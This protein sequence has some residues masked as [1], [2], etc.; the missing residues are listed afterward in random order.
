MHSKLSLLSCMQVC[1]VSLL[2]HKGTAGS[3]LQPF[4]GLGKGEL[5]FPPDLLYCFAL[6]QFCETPACFHWHPFK[7]SFTPMPCG[8]DFHLFSCRFRHRYTCVWYIPREALWCLLLICYAMTRL[9]DLTMIA[10]FQ[11]SF[12]AI[13]FCASPPAPIWDSCSLYGI[14]SDMPCVFDCWFWIAHACCLISLRYMQNKFSSQP[15]QAAIC[16]TLFCSMWQ[17]CTCSWYFVIITCVC[18]C[19]LGSIM[20]RLLAFVEIHSDLIFFSQVVRDEFAD[21]SSSLEKR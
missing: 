8:A 7:T 21:L 13:S 19:L 10:L 5:L 1:V 14:Y 2:L 18:G 9:H 16:P 11:V 15:S 17:G 3:T 20:S 4:P 6:S 12:F